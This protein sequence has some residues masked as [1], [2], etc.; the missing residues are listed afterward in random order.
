MLTTSTPETLL[1]LVPKVKRGDHVSDFVETESPKPHESGIEQREIVTATLT[2][3]MPAS[4]L[5][6][7]GLVVGSTVWSGSTIPEEIVFLPLM[8][9]FLMAG[10]GVSLE[11]LR[12]FLHPDADVSGRR[13]V[14][15]GVLS[16]FA[17]VLVAASVSQF[18]NIR[19]AM[20]AAV[21][22]GALALVGAALPVIM[23]F[24]WLTP[25]RDE[26]RPE[27]KEGT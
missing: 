19:G 12:R 6:A 2:R 14:I 26:M 8:V 5:S 24:P 4:I 10:F 11:V 23:F 1:P 25:T 9:V 13:S 27:S 21:S 7:V 17:Y 3:F 22:M 20:V 16:P 15:A 18:S